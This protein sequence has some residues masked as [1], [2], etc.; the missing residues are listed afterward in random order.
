MAKILSENDLKQLFH[1]PQAM[2]DLLNLVEDSLKAHSRGAVPG[3]SRVETSLVDS[4]RKYRIMTAAVPGAG[5]GAR[6]SA[7]FRAPETLTFICSST[8][9][10]AICSRLSPAGI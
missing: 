3:Q 10:A 7:L 9:I 8:T 2:D 4:K 5:L 1:T 6:I